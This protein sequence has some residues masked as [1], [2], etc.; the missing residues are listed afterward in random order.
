MP[1]HALEL[2]GG[3]SIID[4][5]AGA[6]A[7]AGCAASCSLLVGSLTA[8]PLC[9][10]VADVPSACAAAPGNKTSHAAARLRG[11]G[12]QAAS[13][14]S[15]ARSFV[16]AVGLRSKPSD[17]KRR[18]RHGARMMH[19]PLRRAAAALCSQRQRNCAA[20]AAARVFR[21][22]A[23]EKD[24]KRVKLLR[25]TVRRLAAANVEVSQCG[26]NFHSVRK[27]PCTE[28]GAGDARRL[29]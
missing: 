3:E 14:P 7:R 16:C 13:R 18:S 21:I 17:S 28:A 4:G 12:R 9:A 20:T 25:E 2:R 6:L 26:A 27:P 23:F 15:A 19:A 22:F 8:R 5:F 1:A 24:A 29:P 10:T 11:R